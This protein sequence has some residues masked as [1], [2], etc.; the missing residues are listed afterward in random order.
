MVP[1]CI[2]VPTFV[3]ISVGGVFNSRIVSLRS[4]LKYLNINKHW[5]VKTD[6]SN[7]MLQKQSHYKIRFPICRVFHVQVLWNV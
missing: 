4:M 2:A 3:S 7:K 5:K 1:S 6:R